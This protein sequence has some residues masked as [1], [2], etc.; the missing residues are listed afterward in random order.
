MML[1][2]LKNKVQSVLDVETIFQMVLQP[3]LEWNFKRVFL[4]N[5]FLQLARGITLIRQILPEIH[6]KFLQYLLN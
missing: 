1:Q 5:T 2:S 4:K 3:I 6:L